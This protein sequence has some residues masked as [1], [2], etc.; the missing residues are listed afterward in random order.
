[1]VSAVCEESET[2]GSSV[3]TIQSANAIAGKRI[4]SPSSHP[5]T[6]KDILSNNT[7]VFKPLEEAEDRNEGESHVDLIY[8][9]NN[10][11]SGKFY[12]IL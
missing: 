2:L 12:S 3:K 5:P 11:R 6:S 10:K 7:K 8:P 9:Q 1:M 4:E